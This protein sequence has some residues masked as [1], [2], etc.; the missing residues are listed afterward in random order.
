[1]ICLSLC[2]MSYRLKFIVPGKKYMKVECVFENLLTYKTLEPAIM[3]EKSTLNLIR[4][5]DDTVASKATPGR[6][7]KLG[8]LSSTALFVK[9]QFNYIKL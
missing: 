1:M 7:F 4:F 9:V 3:A 6:D 2:E 8:L 5:Y